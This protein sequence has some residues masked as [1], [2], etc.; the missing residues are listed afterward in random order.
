M[1]C[2]VLAG[3]VA[4]FAACATPPGPSRP[5]P[6]RSA[7]RAACPLGIS[8]VDVRTED[9]EAGIAVVVTAR[10]ED[11]A[12]LRERAH[13]AAKLHGPFGRVGKGH[14]GRHGMGGQHGLQAL[15][16]PPSRASTQEIEGGARIE[17]VP[18]HTSDRKALREAVRDHTEVMRTKPCDVDSKEAS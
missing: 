15:S 16:F 13:D 9:T 1:R 14:D 7:D 18:K 4:V 12:E 5:P 6:T 2:V 10:A 11:V 3:L 8:G 17:I